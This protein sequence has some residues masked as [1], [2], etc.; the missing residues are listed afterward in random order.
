MTSGGASFANIS[1][2]GLLNRQLGDS[3]CFGLSESCKNLGLKTYFKNSKEKLRFWAS[4]S[5][6][7]EICCNPSQFWRKVAVGYAI[8]LVGI[9]QLLVQV[10]FLTHNAA[11]IRLYR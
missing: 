5:P 7:S 4:V 2:K 8:A 6:L 1:W 9:L 3:M 11:G 10:T